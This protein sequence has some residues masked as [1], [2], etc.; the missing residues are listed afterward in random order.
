MLNAHSTIGPVKMLRQG[1]TKLLNNGHLFVLNTLFHQTS[2]LRFSFGNGNSESE[3]YY[4]CISD[5]Y[6]PR[7]LDKKVSKYGFK[8]KRF[9]CVKD[10][11][12]KRGSKA[13][14]NLR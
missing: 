5:E 8:F 9:S 12:R 11:W 10:D 4:F 2:N 14:K 7:S 1:Q 6:S 13:R 3:T